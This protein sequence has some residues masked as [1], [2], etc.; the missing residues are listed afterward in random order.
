MELAGIWGSFYRI[1]LWI[2]RLA[3]LNILWILFTIIGFIVFGFMPATV[4]L[5]TV[6]RKWIHREVDVPVFQTFLNSFKSEFKKANL[7]G[8]IIL[9]IGIILYID[10]RYIGSVVDSPFYPILLG[11]L[12]LA[13][14][15]YFILILYIVPI[16]VHFN[17]S[18]WQYMRY[19]IMIGLTNIHYSIT[20][21]VVLYGLYLLNMNIPGLFPFFA[22]STSAFVVMWIANLSFMDLKRKQDKIHN[23]EKMG[24]KTN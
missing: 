2:M 22:L 1:S 4:A 11:V 18:F 24:T 9:I 8:I 20:M 21:V 14:I 15:I 3:Y 10:L 7:F 6:I 5:F 17:L 16:Y 13:G 23:K 12:F 19:A